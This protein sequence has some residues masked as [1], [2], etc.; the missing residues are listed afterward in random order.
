[1]DTLDLWTQHLRARGLRP[2]TI[3]AY[4]GWVRRLASWADADPATLTADELERWLAQHPDWKPWTHAKAVAAVSYYFRWLV[5]TG[6]RDDDPAADLRPA[7]RPQPCPDP[8]PQDVYAN[9]LDHAQGQDYWRLRLAAD[10]GMRRAELA[11]CHSSDVAQLVT[12][13]TLRIDGK[14]GR[15]RWVPI[16]DDLAQWLTFQRGYAFP[17]G[18]RHMTPMGVGSWYRRHLG[19]HVHALRHRYATLAYQ[20]GHDLNAVRQLLGH[21]DAATTQCYLAVADEDLRRA[22]SGAWADAA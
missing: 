13:P 17:V 1:M 18:D 5:R 15:V 20:Q 10:T 22:A 6:R 12:G 8:C 4:T 9:A 11:R 21:S 19:L 16:P 7:R 14:G 3:D 2:A